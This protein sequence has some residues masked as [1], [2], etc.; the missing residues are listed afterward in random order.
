VKRG[1]IDAFAT[2]D[3][4]TASI[5][6]YIEPFYYCARRHSHVG[7]VS[8]IELRSQTQAIAA[9]SP[10]PLWRGKITCGKARKGG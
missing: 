6:D 1:D 10:C 8:P 3:I 2:R 4:G 9:Y 5:A 7:Y